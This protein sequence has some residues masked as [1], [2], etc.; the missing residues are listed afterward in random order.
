MKRHVPGQP[1]ANG[2]TA[3]R[4]PNG[5]CRECRRNSIQRWRL[6]N[7][8]KNRAYVKAYDAKRT[9]RYN[10]KAAIRMRAYYRKKM[11]IPEATRPCPT[12]C[13]SCGRLLVAGKT[14]LDH[15]HATG[16]FRGWLCNGCNLA[17]GT[18]GDTIES[19]SRALAYLKR[20]S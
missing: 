17:I 10:D 4:S 14:H 7:P 9:N 16:K 5:T 11:G 12:N 8:E 19:V 6:R 2:H 3:P 1:C 20:N 18:L 13:E 15:D